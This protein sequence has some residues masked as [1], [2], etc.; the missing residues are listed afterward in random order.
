LP[1]DPSAATL[2]QRVQSYPIPPLPLGDIADALGDWRDRPGP[3]YRRLAQALSDAIARGSL[4][5]P[6]RLPSERALAGHL[7]VARNTV[8]AAYDELRGMGLIRTRRG[9][10]SVLVSRSRG[11]A[12]QHTALLSRLVGEASAPID[13]A[14]S[15]LHAAPG[16]FP[17]VAM[18]LRTASGLVPAHGY[19]PLGV[20]DL[21]AAIAA[22][23]LSRGLPTEPDQVIVTGGGQ[24]AISLVAQALLKPGDRVLVEAPTY[25]AAI[26]VFL[27]AGAVV[28]ALPCD[29]AGPLPEELAHAL[30]VGPA[31]LLYLIPTCHN[32]TGR[33]M[34]EQRRREL[35][36]LAGES[37]VLV[38]DDDVL[39]GLLPGVQPPLL[40]ALDT[41][42]V[43]TVGSLSKTVWGG[44]RV[45]WI[46]ASADLALRL[47]RVAA[48]RD[49]GP[50]VVGQAVGLEILKQFDTILSRR[51]EV[52]TA[53]M[54]ALCSELTDLIP[55]WHFEPPRGGYSVWV[56]LP[57][58]SAD[59]LVQAALRQ[60][61]GV[62]SGRAAS[63]AGDF[64]T[65]IRLSAGPPADVI[66]EGV[67]RLAL[68]WEELEGWAPAA[69][70]GTSVLV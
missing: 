69:R 43:V 24:G 48:S 55:D 15:A 64:P 62:A 54:D 38:V 35:A 44:L 37:G 22:Q 51:R 6:A 17:E 7:R 23:F 21:R 11:A 19:A 32:P 56:R 25:P 28:E 16:D 57:R 30:S 10:G 34:S 9:S 47:G 13:L 40:A 12:G 14:L 63:P 53:R 45:G 70:T 46:R 26:E 49:L 31:R 67:R 18:S 65:H 52:A 58:G 41:A 1:L 3:A 61:V 42:S 33:V 39:A 66:R 8:V 5:A 60:G 29:H 20:P 36:R 2:Q 59:D 50:S 27:M 68:A 4:A